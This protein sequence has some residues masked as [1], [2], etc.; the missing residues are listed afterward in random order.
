PLASVEAIGEYT[1]QVRLHAPAEAAF[2]AQPAFAATRAAAG[3]P[4]PHGTGGYRVDTSGSALRLVRR[5]PTAGSPGT[6]HVERWS[7]DEERGALDD[8]IDLLVTGEPATI[9]YARLLDAYTIAPLP[10]DRTYALVTGAYPPSVRPSMEDRAALARDAAPAG[11]RAAQGASVVECSAAPTTSLPSAP[12]AAPSHDVR[13]VLYTRG[14]A[15]ARGVAERIA[16]LSWP[17]S[18]TPAWLRTRLGAASASTG[19]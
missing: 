19:P 16:A 9:A 13:R 5:L 4:W 14:D 10:W 2:F 15:V 7:A 18:R 6:L 3:A 17:A 11:T 1:L 8:G 12:A